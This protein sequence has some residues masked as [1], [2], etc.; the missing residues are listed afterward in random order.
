MNATRSDEPCRRRRIALEI[1]DAVLD[2]ARSR[3]DRR[4]TATLVDQ[5][6]RN[7]PLRKLRS[8]R[9]GRTP[10]AISRQHGER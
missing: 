4:H 6:A 5:Q 2:G 8:S 9:P 3:A 10:Q 1:V 7:A